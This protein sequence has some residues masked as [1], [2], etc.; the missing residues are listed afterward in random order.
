MIV[1]QNYLVQITEQGR[2]RWVRT[3]DFVDTSA[4]RWK[5]A[6]NGQGIIPVASDDAGSAHFLQRR[7]SFVTEDVTGTHCVSAK[8]ESANKST[9][10]F[11]EHFTMMG[12]I[13]RLLS[14]TVRKNTWIYVAVG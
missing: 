10:T 9:R 3:G 2:L 4:G 11:Q 13:E 14:Q 7:Q 8:R 5:D 12:M 1:G 6:G